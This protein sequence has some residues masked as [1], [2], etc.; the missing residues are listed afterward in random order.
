MANPVQF[1]QRIQRR[2]EQVLLRTAQVKARAF[3]AASRAVIRGTP[4][5]SGRTRANWVAS[6]GGRDISERSIRSAGD[7]IADAVGVAE[8]AAL[9]QSIHLANGG[10]K[11]PHLQGLNSGTSAKAPAG[12]FETGA[13]K[14]LAAVRGF[15]LLIGK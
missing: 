8:S 4:V 14:G 6:I 10:P 11:A 1:A 12:F 3:K 7:V 5:D 2:A 15:R 13:L 9:E